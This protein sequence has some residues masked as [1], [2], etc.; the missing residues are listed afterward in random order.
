VAHEQRG[1]PEVALGDER[2]LL[3]LL[4]DEHRGA[5][6]LDRLLVL[7]LVLASMGGEHE[8]RPDLE[9]RV[10]GQAR[11]P[12]ALEEPLVRLGLP[13]LPLVDVAEQ[14]QSFGLD[15]GPVQPGS[16]F[17]DFEQLLGRLLEESELHRGIAALNA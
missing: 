6:G 11:Q 5:Q 13:P 17:G 1:D 2:R 15:V 9:A 4:R 14:H 8:R 16:L 7:T 12:V 3:D 10:G